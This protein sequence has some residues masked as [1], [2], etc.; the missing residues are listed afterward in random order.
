MA[1][2]LWGVRGR[3]AAL[4]SVDD[5]SCLY[6]GCIDSDAL[7]YDPTATLPGPCTSKLVGCTSSMASNYYVDANA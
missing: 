5:G 4:A 1:G 7:N 2:R 3:L 6:I